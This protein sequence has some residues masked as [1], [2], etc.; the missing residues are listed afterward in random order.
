MPKPTP[1]PLHEPASDAEKIVAAVHSQPHSYLGMHKAQQGAANGVVVRAFVPDAA[2][3]EVVA[4]STKR[5]QA[6]Q[7]IDKA[8]LFEVLLP[9]RKDVFKYQLRVTYPDGTVRQFWDP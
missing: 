5:S 2:E 4:L 7:Q 8:G 9:R 6:M 3:C 1:E